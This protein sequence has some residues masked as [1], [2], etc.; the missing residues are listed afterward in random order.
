MTLTPNNYGNNG[1]SKTQTNN[2]LDEKQDTLVSGTNIK[3]ING[4]T[5]LGSGN[6]EIGEGGTIVVDQIYDPT[7][8]H[9]QSGV[10]VADALSNSVEIVTQNGTISNCILEIPQNI[11]LT[12]ENNVVTLKSGSVVVRGGEVY[13]T[14]T[15]S[16]DKSLTISLDDGRYVLFTNAVGS[17]LTIIQNKFGSGTTL[18]EDSSVYTRFFITTNTTFYNWSG[19]QNAW[20]ESGI[21]YPIAMIDVVNGVASFAKD[22]NNNDMIFNGAGFV[23][24]HAFIYPN[25]K[26]LATNGI[27][28]DGSLK[29]IIY[30]NTNL[31]ITEMN[32]GNNGFEIASN[33]AIYRHKFGEDYQSIEELENDGVYHY[34]K[35]DNIYAR[36]AN[37][38]L[39]KNS[40]VLFIK[41]NYDGTTVID[42]TICQPVRLATTEMFDKVQDQVDINTT[43]ISGKQ[44]TLVSGTN[45]KTINSTTVLGSG[46]FALADQSL[47]NLDSNG[48]MI[49][50]SQNGTISN[51]ILE[52]PQNLKQ[53]LSNNVLTLKAG[54]VI[55]LCGSTYSTV[56][57][58]ADLTVTISVNDTWV[59]FPHSNGTAISNYIRLNRIGSGSTIPVDNTN[60]QCFFNTT[61]KKIYIYNN[62]AW[63]EWNVGYP[64]CVIKVENGNMSFTKDSNGNDMIFNGAGFIGHHAVVYPNVKGL[65]A[66]GFNSNGTLNNI[67]IKETALNIVE[68][69]NNTTMFNGYTRALYIAINGAIAKSY[70]TFNDVPKLTDLAN[71]SNYYG[72]VDEI[73][74]VAHYS[75]G[76]YVPL[77]RLYLL[78][79]HCTNDVV[80]DFTIQRQPVRTATVE[81][82]NKK[83]ADLT[84]VSGYDATTTQ[85]LKHINGVLTWVTK[86]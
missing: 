70:Y 26:V 38:V 68:L 13:T 20:V 59:V 81:M 31:F 7:S 52:I 64:I 42:F 28:E 75:S 62:G 83:Q 43:A 63:I 2:L 22:S 29:S 66:S 25:V 67:S 55:T 76:D 44:D 45:I 40:I 84:T 47:S 33:T 65:I 56:T 15:L 11:K 46:N 69:D 51:C 57:T 72:Y 61:D 80:D 37:N 34:I 48:Q 3:T 49:V 77:S 30:N 1:Y 24:H 4:N 86:E 60:Y 39:I 54:S 10:A 74:S 14:Y 9:A 12:L 79:F 8:I 27:N 53:E 73:N 18:P 85:V 5:V 36:I 50:D 23:G 58:S 71:N 19:L 32:N 35:N 16:E 6:I 41:Y 82:L 17:P 78:S 21:T